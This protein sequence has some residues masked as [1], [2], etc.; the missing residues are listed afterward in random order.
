V[1]GN[2]VHRTLT[3]I[4]NKFDSTI[5]EAQGFDAKDEEL[6]RQI[7]GCS[8]K[9]GSLLD[10]FQ[11][12]GALAAVVDLARNGNQYLSE[13]EP[14]HL[15]KTDRAKTATTLYMAAQLVC[16]ISVLLSPFLP[17]TA[18]QI[19]AQLNLD[20]SSHRW[21]DGGRLSLSPGHKIG[22]PQPLFHKITI[23]AQS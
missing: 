23:P 20:H 5:P 9:I 2:F 15:I 4:V 22:T 11:L 19:S 7:E 6:K 14:W 18:E 1:L 16:S 21:E 3:F 10:Q 8:A 17:A 12:K 13:R